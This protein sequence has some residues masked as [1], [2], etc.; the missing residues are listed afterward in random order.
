MQL[1]TAEHGAALAPK[2]TLLSM[3]LLGFM[4]LPASLKLLNAGDFNHG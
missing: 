2:G 1:R 4:L 3:E